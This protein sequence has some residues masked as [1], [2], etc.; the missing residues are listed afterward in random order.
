MENT[1]GLPKIGDARNEPERN[2]QKLPKWLEEITS[3]IS[4]EYFEDPEKTVT[5][6]KPAAFGVNFSTSSI[7][8]R[9]PFLEGKIGDPRSV[10]SS[11]TNSAKYG[12]R[13]SI[14]LELY[15]EKSPKHLTIT[16]DYVVPKLDSKIEIDRIMSRIDQEL[17][18]SWK[19]LSEFNQSHKGRLPLE[20][21]KGMN[22]L[23]PS[24]D[25]VSANNSDIDEDSSSDTSFERCHSETSNM[26]PSHRYGHNG[27]SFKKTMT[28]NRVKEETQTVFKSKSSETVFE[29][30]GWDSDFCKRINS[31]KQRL[32]EENQLREM[33]INELLFD[34]KET[35][36]LDKRGQRRGTYPHDENFY[37]KSGFERSSFVIPELPRGK[38]LTINILTTWGDKYY[39]GLNG[40]EIFNE[41][42]DIPKVQLISAVPSDVNILPEC[43]NDPRIVSNLLDG[44]NRTKDD[45]HIWLAPFYSGKKHVITI[46]FFQE[47]TV[48]LIRI[49]NYNKSRIHSYRGARDIVMLLDDKTIFRGEI[50]K[51]AGGTQGGI[52]HFGDTILFT[53]DELIL[54]KISFNDTS[55]SVLKSQP[56]TPDFIK[57]DR[58]PTSVLKPEVRPVT[59]RTPPLHRSQ[60]HEPLLLG[61]KSIQLVLM[62]N[63]GN[64]VAIGLTGIEIIEGMDNILKME[65]QFLSCNVEN[66][67]LG[68]LIDGENVTTAAKNMWCVPWQKEND[69]FIVISIDFEEFKYISGLRVWNYNDNLEFTYVGVKFLKVL[70]D[71]RLITNATLNNDCFLLRRAPGNSNYDFVQDIRFFD[72]PVMDK[73]YSPIPGCLYGFVMEITIYSTW[74]DQYY[75]GLNGLEL[76][77][78]HGAKIQLDEQ[79]SIVITCRVGH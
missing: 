60:S 11:T 13:S 17:E 52:K 53:T 70:L 9:I 3:T 55:F 35:V 32:A 57:E 43:Q 42:G 59:G 22:N 29:Q 27:K 77:D 58:P 71:N 15:K 26:R 4:R 72:Q 76:Y 34:N 37:R 38:I 30:K 79:S 12:R 24:S 40:I 73:I 31:Y 64:P 66:E 67:N 2:E 20:R 65:E 33:M 61:A 25:L 36:G 49:W 78:H 63:W 10:N 8:N 45:L 54:E 14:A 48:A 56:P 16:S 46:E 68:A 47:V 28:T 6:E 62:D 23:S 50:A 18:R 5:V 19:S 7:P 69:D 21:K 51:A 75:C 44:I 39:V 41:Q 1:E 74:G